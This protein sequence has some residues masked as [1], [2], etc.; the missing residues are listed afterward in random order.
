M[1]NPYPA[2]AVERVRERIATTLEITDDNYVDCI[3]IADLAA[4][5]SYVE[6]MKWRPI[7]RVSMHWTYQP[8]PANL[9]GDDQAS[10]AVLLD[11]IA[12]RL[13]FSQERMNAAAE[14]IPSWRE[15]PD[16]DKDFYR[17]AIIDLLSDPELTV[18]AA[19]YRGGGDR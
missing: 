1:T 15:L 13:H 17:A 10:F 14:G 11:H 3:K 4:L 6:G 19:L 5:L 8:Q 9:E 18:L 2:E 7:E 16:I 12:A